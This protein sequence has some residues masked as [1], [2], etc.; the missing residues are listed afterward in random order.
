MYLLCRDPIHVQALPQRASFLSA[1]GI[2]DRK[3]VVVVAVTR[4]THAKY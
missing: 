3:D 1:R 2:P 4:S